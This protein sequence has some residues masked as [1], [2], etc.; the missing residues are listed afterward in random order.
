[1]SRPSSARSCCARSPTPSPRSSDAL[2]KVSGEIDRHL[3][4]TRLEAKAADKADLVAD[5]PLLPTRR[6][7]WERALRAID[8]A[9]KAGVLR[10][11]L[12]IVHEAARSVADQPLGTS[13][14]ATSCSIRSRRAC[15]RAAS[16][17]RRS[18]S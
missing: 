6:R 16:C 5:Y 14:A 7:F 17:S 3:G 15:C 11:Q 4:G 18:T 9:G 12:K 2:D 13:S 10:T 8:K 1:M